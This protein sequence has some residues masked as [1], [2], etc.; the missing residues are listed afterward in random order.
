MKNQRFTD[1]RIY[2]DSYLMVHLCVLLAKNVF[3]MISESGF[4]SEII[5]LASKKYSPK[6]EKEK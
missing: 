3:W 4:V 1:F 6:I 5:I 2:F